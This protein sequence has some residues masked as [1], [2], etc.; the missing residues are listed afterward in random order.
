M[1]T[2]ATGSTF[3]YNLIEA[4]NPLGAN[5]LG[6]EEAFYERKKYKDAPYFLDLP[7]P[8]KSWYDKLYFGRVDTI[9]NGILVKNGMVNPPGIMKK[10]ETKTGNVFVLNFV[11]DAFADLRAHLK[12]VSTV[13]IINQNSLYNDIVPVE[14]YGDYTSRF[15][16]LNK[17]W[18]SRLTTRINSKKQIADRVLD[19]KTYMKALLNY[20]SSKVN[21]MPLTLSGYA[22]SN[23]ASPMVSGLAVTLAT[24]NYGDDAVKFHKYI[25]DPNFTYFVEAARKY[26]FYVDRNAP[27]KLI[28][29]P[30]SEP[31]LGYLSHYKYPLMEE[32]VDPSDPASPTSVNKENF[33]SA[34]YRKTYLSD[35]AELQNTLLNMYNAFVDDYPRIVKETTGTTQCPPRSKGAGYKEIISR[36][37]TNIATLETYGD[38]YWLNIYFKIRIQEANLEYPH[39]KQKFNQVAQIYKVYGLERATRYINNEI[40]PYLYNLRLGKKGLTRDVGVVTI[41]TVKDAPT[42][43]VGASDSGGSDMGGGSSY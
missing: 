39:Y 40:K 3:P 21:D 26:G 43:V 18:G 5:D 12:R 35:V 41:G 8:L 27:W 33:F 13:G 24:E 10:I 17:I 1:T 6:S 34:Y 36:H 9:Q 7:V 29:D 31:M 25:L 19:F 23:F 42:V 37:T 32:I 11:A 16:N 4:M 20:M 30:L 28:A 15:K 14:G 38:L 2:E 22:V